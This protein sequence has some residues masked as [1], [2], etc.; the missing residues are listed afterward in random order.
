MIE[1]LTGF[2]VSKAF[3]IEISLNGRQFSD[4]GLK[5]KFIENNKLTKTDI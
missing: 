4:N 2:P 5:F 3:T 1:S